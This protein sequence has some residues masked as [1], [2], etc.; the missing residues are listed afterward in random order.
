MTAS[1][2]SVSQ[3]PRAMR[4]RENLIAAMVRMLDRDPVPPTINDLVKEAGASR[5]TFY[6]RFGDIPTLM[7]AAAMSRL[8]EAFELMREPAPGARWDAYAEHN[9]TTLLTH[10]GDH[11]AFYLGMFDGPS[12]MSVNM[13]FTEFI[14]DRLL[15]RSPLQ[16]AIRERAAQIGLA[17]EELARFLA[18]GAMAL[19]NQ[20]LRA[21]VPTPHLAAQLSALF[22]TLSGATTGAEQ[23]PTA[24]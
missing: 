23:P 20:G 22:V 7:H 13:R 15:M 4:S 3:D 9:L 11:R 24:P 2:P 14:A 21:D 16:H 10:V 8:Q 17:P 6:Q 5:P 1:A 12:G 18:G 19:V